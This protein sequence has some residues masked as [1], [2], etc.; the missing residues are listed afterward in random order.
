MKTLL[1]GLAAVLFLAG[2]AQAA[3]DPAVLS[4]TLPDHIAWKQDKPDGPQTFVLWGDPDKPGPYA[5]LVRWPPHHMS[6]PHFHPHDRH[7][8]VL[9]GTWWVGTGKTYDPD[10][11]TPM[12]A[13]AVVTHFANQFHYDGAKDEAAVLEIVGEGPQYN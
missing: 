2:G 4:Y 6:R 1:G 9:S 3:P 10:S 11:T 7:I 13:G 12:P 5:L 8:V